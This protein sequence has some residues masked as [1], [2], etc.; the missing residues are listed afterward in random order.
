MASVYWIYSV[1]SFPSVALRLDD[2]MAISFYLP[3]S[4][5]GRTAVGKMTRLSYIVVNS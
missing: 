3:L 1:N 2:D 4:I 5:S